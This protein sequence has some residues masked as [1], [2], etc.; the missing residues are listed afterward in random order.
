MRKWCR[1]CNFGWT[2][3]LKENDYVRPTF[4]AFESPEITFCKYYET[5]LNT[6]LG[7][8]L[9]MAADKFN[10][11]DPSNLKYSVWNESS[12]QFSV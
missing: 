8:C 5:K 4:C 3:P 6:P 1:I 7:F 2:V 12:S 10:A 9:K 11:I